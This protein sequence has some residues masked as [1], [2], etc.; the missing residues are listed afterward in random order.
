MMAEEKTSNPE[1]L[2]GQAAQR[3]TSNAEKRK[4]K[5]ERLK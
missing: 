2:S 1:K 5:V 4:L 3:P